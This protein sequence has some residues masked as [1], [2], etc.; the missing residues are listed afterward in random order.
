MEDRDKIIKDAEKDYKHKF[1]GRFSLQRRLEID[2][3]DFISVWIRRAQNDSY[4][5]GYKTA[6][7]EF[8]EK[9]KS[10]P[11]KERA[12]ISKYF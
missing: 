9:L 11:A 1:W 8:K 10:V 7:E 4:Q 6:Q 12:I 3:W 5:K 2:I